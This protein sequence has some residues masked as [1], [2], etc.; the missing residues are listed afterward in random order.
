MVNL[1]D[2]TIAGIKSMIGHVESI[3]YEGGGPGEVRSKNN[4]KVAI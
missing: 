3:R 4:E 1:A 2:M